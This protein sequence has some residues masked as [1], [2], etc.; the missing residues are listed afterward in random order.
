MASALLPEE[1]AEH[2][3]H[4]VLAKVLQDALAAAGILLSLASSGTLR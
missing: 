1:C 4:E 2:A 3:A